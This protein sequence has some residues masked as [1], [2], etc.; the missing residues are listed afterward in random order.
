MNGEQPLYNYVYIYIT[1][2]QQL[3]FNQ[4]KLELEFTP[5]TVH[6][7]SPRQRKQHHMNTIEIHHAQTFLVHVNLAWIS[8]GQYIRVSIPKKSDH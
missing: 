3:K 8:L 1:H 7:S 2:T 5:D 4:R 6:A